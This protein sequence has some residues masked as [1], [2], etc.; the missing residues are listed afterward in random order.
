M[1]GRFVTKD[2]TQP[3]CAISSE[4]F[5]E[6]WNEELQEWVF[7]DAVRLTASVA[8]ELGLDEGVIV[9]V[10]LL[11][12]DVLARLTSEESKPAVKTEPTSHS[13][14]QT[15]SHTDTK[16]S[17]DAMTMMPGAHLNKRIKL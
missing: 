1:V 13:F 8:S 16:R 7:I 9:K 5:K 17:P 12:D 11:D 14:G 6:E 4:P 15:F 2:E 10:G 3:L